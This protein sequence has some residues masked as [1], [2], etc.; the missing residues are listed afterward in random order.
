MAKSGKKKR[1]QARKA[2][3]APAP[4]PAP[5]PMRY[6]LEAA[7]PWASLLLLVAGTYWTALFADF[8]W[9]DKVFI[10]ES[11]QI[12]DWGGLARIWLDPAG[13]NE[14]HYWPVL[15]TSFWLDHK[16]WAWT[17]ALAA[18]CAGDFNPAGFH[19][20][21]LL[22]HG[23]NSVLL[24]RILKHI[25][26]PGAWLIAAIFAVHP[27]HAEPVAW[28]TARKDLLSACFYLLAFGAWLRYRDLLLVR[29][30]GRSRA[31]AYSLLL[32]FYAAAVLSKTV[33]IT[34]PLI[35]LLWVWWQHGR[36]A[37]R[38][39]MQTAPLF[40]LGIAL[41]LYGLHYYSGRAHI[42][43]DYS[44]AERAVIAA[45]ALWFYV[46]KLLS[47]HTLLVIY[48]HWDVEP[49]RLLNWLPLFAALGAFAGLAW[50]AAGIPWPAAARKMG[51]RRLGRGPLAGALF[52]AITLAPMLGFADNSYMKFSF[53]ADRY[54]YLASIGLITAI[55]GGA[56]TLC[57][58]LVRQPPLDSGPAIIAFERIMRREK[59][60]NKKLRL[61]VV[62]RWFIILAKCQAAIFLLSYA[63]TS[64]EQ[65]QLF[66]DDAA[67]FFHVVDT[68]PD[69]P[70][71][72]PSLGG[73]LM[74]DDPELAAAAFW[75]ALKLEPDDVH[76]HVR[77]SQTLIELEEY[78]TAEALL[79]SAL[80]R[81]L[82]EYPGV[83]T[84]LRKSHLGAKLP[85]NLGRVWLKLEQPAEAEAAFRRALRREPGNVQFRT[86][87][88]AALRD[89]GRHSEAL[90]VLRRTASAMPQPTADIYLRMAE[91]A[92]AQGRADAA[93]DF[94]RQALAA[95]P[96]SVAALRPY[97]A[98]RYNAGRY[99][100][101]LQLYRRISEL[102]PG[103]INAHIGQGISLEGLGRRD[104][105]K[106][107][108]ERALALDPEHAKARRLMLG[109]EAE[110]NRAQG[111]AE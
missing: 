88:S 9:D 111:K 89:Q 67:L 16:L 59:E 72:W 79:L 84:P 32:A 33:A 76:T 36:I 74:K 19:A 82:D 77:L 56:V 71:A 8:V 68:N 12:R 39:C 103:D 5:F 101:A 11:A 91:I 28:V 51:G 55:I 17:C 37:R 20:T 41:G 50:L 3:A 4:A 64:W 31:G 10:L 21:N 104:E 60:Q 97:A 96:H 85:Y 63:L 62:Q 13:A 2:D 34:L 58:W 43:F 66:Q 22:L 105:A 14:L 81:E 29:S 53:A 15:N 93:V 83:D 99:G 44:F 18:N 98:T 92:A 40:L 107:A 47:P 109:I 61:P 30:R 75:K 86:S 65:A 52:F 69:A 70:R 102:V 57:F 7:L 26:V 94:N 46:G 27:V 23:V 108:Y 48:P 38:D 110:L 80:G 54:Q 90:A 45:K 49:G 87:L 95:D 42:A 1:K 6:R 100:E 25:A 78:E 106:Q 24:W 73:A 35:L